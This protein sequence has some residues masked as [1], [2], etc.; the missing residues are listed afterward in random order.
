MQKKLAVIVVLLLIGI[1]GMG[2]GTET[3]ATVNGEKV[4]Q[5]QLEKIINLYVAQA[6][7]VYGTDVT[8]DQEFMGEIEKMAL[9]DL[10][11]QTL[12]IQNA[13]SEGL[14]ATDKEVS[15][16]IKNFKEASGTDGYKN[17][18]KAS[19]MTDEDFKQ[20]MYNQVLVN[21][22]HEKVIAKVKVTEKDIKAYY[23]AHP[24]D[25]GNLRELKVSHIL[26]E[27]KEEAEKVIDRI[28]A[29]EDFG[30][31]AQELSTEPAAKETKGDLGFINE[32][33]NLV[34]EFKEA[35]LKLKPGEMTNEPVKSEF[36]FHVIKAFEEKDAHIEPFAEVKDQ[37]EMLAKRAKEQQAWNDFVTNLRKEAKVETKNK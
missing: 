31:L 23:E 25:F 13:L 9:N 1:V 17:F 3:V 37:A 16:A 32:Q 34:T 36:G 11:D 6:K 20:E 5:P 7:Q 10:I 18:L 29:G 22:L 27:T 8:E 35:A 12:V 4:T 30:T 28:K 2:C 14:E 24:E 21:K 26:L 15:D 33:T 19:G